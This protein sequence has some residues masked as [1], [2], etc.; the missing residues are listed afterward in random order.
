M[1]LKADAGFGNNMKILEE[2]MLLMMYDSYHFLDHHYYDK[3]TGCSLEISWELGD[4][5]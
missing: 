2:N 5:A 3:A 1:S 4:P